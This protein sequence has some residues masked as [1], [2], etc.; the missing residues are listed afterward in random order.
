VNPTSTITAR[1]LGRQHLRR[2]PVNV[3]ARDGSGNGLY[4]SDPF[5]PSAPGTYYW[6]A[7]YSGDP[8]NKH[9][10]ALQ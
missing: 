1:I 6:R 10:H 5:T 3:D 7:T 4:P 8:S 2:R 9:C